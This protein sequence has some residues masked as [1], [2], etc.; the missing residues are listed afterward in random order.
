MHSITDL[1]AYSQ[2]PLSFAD[3][4]AF[5]YTINP[6][7]A[8][9]SSTTAITYASEDK[10]H[11]LNVPFNLVELKSNPGMILTLNLSSYPSSTIS[12]TNIPTGVTYASP[13]AGIHVYG[14]IVT[15]YQLDYI[16]NNM[17]II[18]APDYYG[19]A[20]YTASLSINGNI[21]DTGNTASWSVKAVVS[22]E[23]EL[24]VATETLFY[25]KIG[26]PTNFN[27]NVTVYDANPA[28]TYW[29][30]LQMANILHGNITSNGVGGSTYTIH[31]NPF[32]ENYYAI[33]GNKAQIDSH[34][35]NLTFT[36]WLIS[37]SAITSIN[38]KLTNK[39]SGTISNYSG[40]NIYPV[41]QFSIADTTFD[42][43]S[44]S[45][46]ANIITSGTISSNI[47]INY[48][49]VP[50]SNFVSS[51]T[52][53]DGENNVVLD[54]YTTP[55]EIGQTVFISNG[56]VTFTANDS[57]K[58]IP[59]T[60]AM[61]NIYYDWTRTFNITISSQLDP[62]HQ[63][64]HATG[65]MAIA[66]GSV[67]LRKLSL[68]AL[69]D[70]GGKRTDI[71]DVN[72][73]SPYVV[74]NIDC[75]TNRGMYMWLH[76]VNGITPNVDYTNSIQYN[77]GT[78]WL[79]YTPWTPIIIPGDT[80][81]TTIL[82]RVPII[83]DTWWESLD[84][85]QRPAEPWPSGQTHEMFSFSCQYYGDFNNLETPISSIPIA[86]IDALGDP[87]AWYTGTSGVGLINPPPGN[88]FD[89]D[90]VLL[91]NN[92]EVNEGSPYAVHTV[93]CNTN[94]PIEF[95]L[96][97]YPF[98]NHATANLDFTNAL[99]YKIGSSSWQNFTTPITV[100]GSQPSADVL[101]RFPIIND[102]ISEG[103]E[104][105]VLRAMYSGV[106]GYRWFNIG[107]T[108]ILDNGLGQ[109]FD[110]TSGIGSNTAP[111]GSTLDNDNKNNLL[112]VGGAPNTS[113]TV[114]DSGPFGHTIINNGV[115]YSNTVTKLTTTSLKFNGTSYLTIN[116]APSLYMTGDFTWEAWIYQS[117]PEDHIFGSII[118]FNASNAG[119]MTIA[120]Y[121][122]LLWESYSANNEM[123]VGNGVGTIGLPKA[124]NIWHHIAVS[125]QGNTWRAFVDGT[126]AHTTTS[127]LIP[128]N[129]NNL[130][131]GRLS[132][133][134]NG[135]Y[136]YMDGIRFTQGTARY[137]A[138][139]TPPSTLSQ[140]FL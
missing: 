52:Y 95:N 123:S 63:I 72:E 126:L 35:A 50:V 36:P 4:R 117:M 44:L 104:D 3:T 111:T 124:D 84:I 10:G 138:N 118:T 5:G 102:N 89:N 49:V 116:N 37:N 122:G 31:S 106:P 47:T 77:Y 19:N 73:G 99:Q 131:I 45:V 61:G 133:E 121:N 125:R 38:Y 41:N 132:N 100:G 46:V 108:F 128:E 85:I 23:A 58:S 57:V 75:N 92:I 54:T 136:G 110:G 14:N 24:N 80:T 9:I 32:V 140:M 113:P 56:S 22:N 127:S 13:S 79:N 29:A 81:T 21:A 11:P 7:L 107:H 1:N 105:I 135:F 25:R 90:R 51:F 83:N 70:N 62:A 109:W 86:I 103:T 48:N 120:Q 93:T 8:V 71:I 139:F 97:N 6:N 74:V 55:A 98:G 91:V 129:I 59:F 33:S 137:V 68:Y 26:Q 18:I 30:N 27:S 16:T 67:S 34:L 78:G 115:T 82:A 39:T 64:T 119:R 87:G 2:S 53:S 130:T 17:G 69:Y 112:I 40:R 20:T 94:W 12:S 15:T 101:V 42:K 65:L 88:E 60:L 66:G 96:Q 114:V 76:G 43:S 134:W 28:I